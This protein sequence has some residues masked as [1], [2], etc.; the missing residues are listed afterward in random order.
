MSGTPEGPVH[1][2]PAE[3]HTAEP[4]LTERDAGRREAELRDYRA[5]FRVARL[6]MALVDRDGVVVAANDSLGAL[7]GTEAGA[8]REQAAADLVDLASD[9]R[10]WHAYREVLR[11]RRSRFRCTRRLKHADGRSLWAEVTVAPVPGDRRVLLSIADISDRR[12]L[13]ARLRHLQMHDPVTRLPNRTLFFERLAA[14]LEEPAAPREPH[15]PHESYESY[16]SYGYG[17]TGRIGLC[18]IDLDGFKAVNDTLGHRVGDRL[19]AAVAGRLTECADSDGYTR[20]GGHLV[21]RLGGDEFA[22]LVEDSTGTE[23]LTDLARSVLDALQEPFDLAGQRLSVS[24]SIGVVERSGRGTT[25]TALMQAADTTL[26][27]AK[28]DGKARWT[29]FDPERNA[30]RMTRQALSS[31]LRPAVEDGEFALEYQ[32]LVDLADGAVR[33]VE[34]L[35]RWHHPQ[36]G[37]LPPNRFIGI[38]EEDGSIVELGRWILRTACRQ[39]RQW[40]KDHPRERPLFVSVNVAVRQVWDSDLV[41]DV[42]GILAETGLAPHLLQ[43]EL[44][45][46]AVMGSAGRP[47]QALQAL[48]D[49]GVRIAIDDFGTGYS[50]LA[51]LSRLPVSVLKL[52]GSFVRGFQ[53]EEHANAA[54]ELIVEAL[55]RLAHRLGLTVTAE[56]VE[57]AGQASRLRRIGCDTGQGWLYSRAVTPERIAE[58]I[59]TEPLPA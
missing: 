13:Q 49:M 30:H 50:N 22:I 55:V 34:A 39:A 28:A 40:Q 47:L 26:Y 11:G 36:F 56:C 35:V 24:A 57:T 58:L 14:A 18:Y 2:E 16:E 31:T 10:T 33:G 20:G 15:E 46:S 27:W 3:T 42:A 51:Y 23:Q 21:A 32:P 8:L 37:P 38:A 54:D 48:S 6:A 17:R 4:A 43:L 45:E 59:G 52:D 53:D 12:E 25:A 1:P 29:L 19:L 7:L 9:G 5:A 44:T 41:A